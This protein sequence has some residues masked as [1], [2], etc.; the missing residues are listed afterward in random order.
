[1]SVEYR[2]LARPGMPARWIQARAKVV[3]SGGITKLVGT[4]RDISD[5]KEA[6]ARQQLVSGELQHRIKNLI[7]M[8]GAIATQTLRGDDIT[9]RRETFN[10]R[11]HVLAQA[12]NMLMSQTSEEAGIYATLRAALA[13]HDDAISRFDISGP[14]FV[15]T[16]KQSLSM[17]LTLH[18]LATNA[19]KYGSLSSGQGRVAISWT[20]TDG[21]ENWRTLDFVWEETGGPNVTQPTSK[22][23]GSRLISR[24]LAADFNGDVRINYAPDGV[25]CVMTA[26]LEK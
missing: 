20:I 7:A 9:E 4:V 15:M 1:M 5:I 16:A 17:A 12:Q 6:E 22:G 25:V 13:P 18:E 19:M 14:E 23:F 10:A 11:L 21:D 24:V 2:M 26:K 8:V 3:T